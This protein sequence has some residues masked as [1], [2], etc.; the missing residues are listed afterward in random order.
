M[1]HRVHRYAAQHDALS[2]DVTGDLDRQEPRRAARVANLCRTVDL[3]VDSVGRDPRPLGV[4]TVPAVVPTQQLPRLEFLGVQ[5]RPMVD[6]PREI[7]ADVVDDHD[8]LPPEIGDTTQI[9]PDGATGADDERV[10]RNTPSQ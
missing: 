7:A 3:A 6:M 2:A 5:C 1:R 10:H 8:A 9:V 4:I